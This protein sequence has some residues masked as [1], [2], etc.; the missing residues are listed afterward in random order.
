M[1][2]NVSLQVHGIGWNAC[3][4]LACHPLHATTAAGNSFTS[5]MSDRRK[6]HRGVHRRKAGSSERVNF[7]FT[8]NGNN[9]AN[10][11]HSRILHSNVWSDYEETAGLLMSL[12]WLQTIQFVRKRIRSSWSASI[13]IFVSLRPLVVSL[14]V[15]WYAFMVAWCRHS[16]NS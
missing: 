13:M 10:L 3:P 12:K 5:D 8:R 6:V 9:A 16:E 1:P 14:G 15:F 7:C 11:V 2:F 4:P